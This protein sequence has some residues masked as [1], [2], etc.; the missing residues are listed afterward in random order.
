M[1][2]SMDSAKK[3]HEATAISKASGGANER[4]SDLEYHY[5]SS[6]DARS[7]HINGVF[8]GITTRGEVY[9][10]FFAEFTPLP[11]SAR[12]SIDKDGRL[13]DEIPGSRVSPGGVNREVQTSVFMS[14]D[15][16]RSIGQWLIKTAAKI[17][18]GTDG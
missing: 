16:A 9:A 1:S 18:E 10:S 6:G 12:Y 7:H 13:G 11:T 15:V 17:E 5:T 3:E 4:P 8:G 14:A 2:E